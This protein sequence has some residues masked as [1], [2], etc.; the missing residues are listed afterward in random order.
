MKNDPTRFSKQ[1]MESIAASRQ[2]EGTVNNLAGGYSFVTT[3]WEQLERI[4]LLGTASG[5]MYQSARELTLDA[6]ETVK[7]CTESDARKTARITADMWKERRLPNQSYAL[8]TFA[9]IA[10]KAASAGDRRYAMDK[11]AEAMASVG[12][13]SHLYEFCYYAEQLRGWGSVLSTGV[14]KIINAWSDNKLALQFV[15]YGSRTFRGNTFGL[16]DLMRLSHVKPMTVQ[17]GVLY[18]DIASMNGSRQASTFLGENNLAFRGFNA[19]ETSA[20]K[21]IYGAEAVRLTSPDDEEKIRWLVDECDLPWEAVPSEHRSHSVWG[22]LIDKMPMNAMLRQLSSWEARFHFNDPTFAKRVVDRMTDDAFI[23]YQRPHP[24]A[25]LKAMK[26]YANGHGDLGSLRWTPRRNVLNALEYIFDK[27]F[28]HVER[29]NERLCIGVDVSGS[30]GMATVHGTNIKAYEGAATM[31]RALL[32]ASPKSVILGFDTG[33]SIAR[34]TPDMSTSKIMSE[35][36]SMPH[37]GTNCSLPINYCTERE[38]VDAFVIIT[39][40]H[41]W[42]G[43][44][45]ESAMARYH[46]ATNNKAKL[47]TVAMC[48]NQFKLSDAPWSL[49]AVGM[50]PA[51]AP[52]VA[53]FVRGG[54]NA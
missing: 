20:R 53:G 41:Y 23:G 19:N 35:F 16:I 5:T 14:A 9:Y 7:A 30:M 31:C 49:C 25:V 36:V 28:V 45:P 51:I 42:D 17:R 47:V 37:G 32:C 13:A 22:V 27:S 38:V 21:M 6:L 54:Q 8:Y 18:A 26:T 11:F 12:T 4:L 24:L 48:S 15:K 39:D 2:M 52:V 10:S 44:Q 3:K 40:S 43:E 46:R 29:M 34:I 33:V 50:D 1:Y